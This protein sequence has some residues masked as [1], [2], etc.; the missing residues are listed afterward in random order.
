MTGEPEPALLVMRAGAIGDLV[1]TLPA[2]AALHERFPRHRLQLAAR[3][4]MLPLLR[5][6]VAADVIPFDSLLLAPL[7]SPDAP[8]S[9]ELLARLGAVQVAVLWLP[10]RQARIVEQRLRLL[11]VELIVC[12]DPLPAGR[13]AADHLLHTLTPL[14]IA[15][16]ADAIPRLTLADC[17]G[18]APHS[19]DRGRD[20]QVILHVGS[21]G[22]AKRWPPARFTELAAKVADLPATRVLVL[23]GPAEETMGIAAVPRSER[24]RMVDSPTLN[25]LTHLLM[26]SVLYVGNDSGITH[27]AAALGRPTVAL[28]GPT[29]PAVWAPRGEHVT[30]VRSPDSTMHSLSI[31]SVWPVVYKR[32]RANA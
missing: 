1:L 11:G 27:L 14:G 31:D 17:G 30:I 24:I 4:D 29:D 8:L 26:H 12:A 5:G 16:E 25:E 22:A 10:E 9:P 28:F 20:S 6:S 23:R 32:L 3:A 13:H 7:F 21:G 19:G 18:L 2:L 15:P